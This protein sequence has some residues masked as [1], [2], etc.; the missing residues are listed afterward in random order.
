MNE[1]SDTLYFYEVCLYGQR[2]VSVSQLGDPSPAG[3]TSSQQ[4]RGQDARH[5]WIFDRLP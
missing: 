1:D 4:D 5:R 2:Y 3:I